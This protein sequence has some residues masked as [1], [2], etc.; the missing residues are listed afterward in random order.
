MTDVAKT[1]LLG[2]TQPEMESFFESIGEKRFRAGQVMKWIHHFG[3]ED[4][5]AMSNLG[6]ALREKLSACAE[7]LRYM[8]STVW[9]RVAVAPRISSLARSWAWAS[10][11][12][13]FTAWAALA[14]RLSLSRM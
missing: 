8:S 11:R 3:V 10:G 1:N 7:I 5:D 13:S 2:L 4:F 12:P 9:I 14:M 6:K